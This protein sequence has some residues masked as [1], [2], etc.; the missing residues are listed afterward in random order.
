MNKQ[1]ILCVE[2]NS[3]AKTDYVYINETINRFYLYNPK[4]RREIIY[5]NG[6]TNYDKHENEIDYSKRH[7]RG[8]TTVIMFID[9]DNY[10]S[11]P[12]DI[13]RWK[14][15]ESYCKQMN[16]ELVF[17][18]KDVE[19]VYLGHRIKNNDKVKESIRF[20]AKKLIDSVDELKLRREQITP[21]SS[22]V[23]LVLDKYL[24]K[25]KNS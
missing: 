15:I 13:K 10:D 3:N 25:R 23:L 17:F 4:T 9:I 22:N 20:R 12:E 1:L 16:Y 7:F 11:D 18:T 19:D 24:D 8:E 21:H 6:K 5:L 2:T 14:N